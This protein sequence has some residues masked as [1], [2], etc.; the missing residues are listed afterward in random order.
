[1]VHSLTLVSVYSSA[2]TIPVLELE[3]CA[4]NLLHV[5][6]FLSLTQISL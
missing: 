3:V 4:N 5:K 6:V 2:S 1:M